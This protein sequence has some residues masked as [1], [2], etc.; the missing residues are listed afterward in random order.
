M[1]ARCAA[2]IALA[3]CLV[4]ASCATTGEEM[5]QKEKDRMAREMDRSSRKQAQ[6]Q[7][8][9]MRQATG[10]GQNMRGFGR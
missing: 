1:K 5:S 9:A 8:R 3:G 10:Q 7:D 6:T 4:L 2:L